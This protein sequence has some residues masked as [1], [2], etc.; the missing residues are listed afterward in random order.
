[1]SSTIKLAITCVIILAIIIAGWSWFGKSSSEVVSLPPS[2]ISTANEKF[3]E[4]S[5][6][7]NAQ[8]SDSSTAITTNTDSSDAGLQKDVD[9]LDAEFGKLDSDSSNIDQSMSAPQE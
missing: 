2:D 4:S 8:S 1:M 3:A 9:D 7:Q 6:T 5:P